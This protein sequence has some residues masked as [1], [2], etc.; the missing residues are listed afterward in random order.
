MLPITFYRCE[1]CKRDYDNMTDAEKCENGHLTITEARIKHY[2]IH[3][4]PFELEIVFSNG[5]KMI[6]LAE[7]LRG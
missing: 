7:H 6:Y 2:G 5:E 1:V 4:H 3:T